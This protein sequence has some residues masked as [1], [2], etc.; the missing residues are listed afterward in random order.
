MHP[1]Y[2]TDLLADLRE[3]VYKKIQAIREGINQIKETQPNLKQHELE[4]FMHSLE[5]NHKLLSHSLLQLER[6]TEQLDASKSI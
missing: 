4:W 1:L 3:E 5:C 6:R 2:V